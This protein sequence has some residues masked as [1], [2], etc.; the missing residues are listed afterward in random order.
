MNITETLKHVAIE[1]GY[2]IM[3]HRK[4]NAPQ[5]IIDELVE[6]WDHLA[7]AIEILDRSDE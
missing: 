2:A 7:S 5:V 4:A 1:L 3:K 6:A